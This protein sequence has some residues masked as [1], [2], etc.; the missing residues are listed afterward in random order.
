MKK[1]KRAK[2]HHHHRVGALLIQYDHYTAEQRA[3]AFEADVF[4]LAAKLDAEQAGRIIDKLREK[5]RVHR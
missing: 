2:A 1:G 4:A 5:M 3:D